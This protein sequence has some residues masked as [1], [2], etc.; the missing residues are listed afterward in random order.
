M[1][2]RHQKIFKPSFE[3]LF[4]KFISIPIEDEDDL[5]YYFA[6]LVNY[7]RPQKNAAIQ[8]VQLKELL[9]TLKNPEK[10]AAFSD[11][12]IALF[13]GRQF[14]TILTDAG[15]LYNTYFRREL[16]KRIIANFIPYQPEK[17]KLEYF[18]NQVFYQRRDYEWISKID[19]GDIDELIELL[20]ISHIYGKLIPTSPLSEVVQAI[21]LNLQR[22]TGSALESAVIKMVPEY[23]E[24]ESPFEALEKE[25]DI[26]EQKIH[27]NAY[28]TFNPEDIDLR[29]F[30]VLSAQC[31]QFIDAA[32]N[33]SSKYGI[34]L[35]VNQSL[36]RIR[37]QL[38]RTEILIEFFVVQDKKEAFQKTTRL[39][40]LLI[41]YNCQKNNIRTLIAEST[42]LISYEVTQHTAK[43]GEHYITKGRREYFSMLKSSTFGGFIVGFLCIFKLYIHHWELSQFGY[44]FFYSMN[45]AFGFIT[46]YLI[47]AT[48]A[49]KQPAMTASAMIQ[50]IE[51]DRHETDRFKRYS[52]FSELTSRLIRS[53]FI[54][55]VG[56]IIGTFSMALLLIYLIQ[57]LTGTNAAEHDWPKLIKDCSPVHSLAIFH[58]AIAGVFL[59]LSG[60]ISGSV[61]NSNKHNRL[62]YRIKEH[63]V[64][65]RNLGK[66]KAEKIASWLEKKWPGVASNFWFGV[67]MGT[68]ASVGAFLGLNLDVRHITFSTGNFAIGNFGSDFG[69]TPDMIFW[70][71][72]GIIIIG[73]MNFI[74]SFI[75]SLG[76]ALRS[77][78]IAYRELIPLFKAVVLRFRV[79]PLSF[80]LPPR[81]G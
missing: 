48:L 22:M 16:K 56:N 8:S 35:D 46:I 21:R 66:A 25:F 13:S 41:K 51:K 6:D 15:I 67:F 36:L 47:G 57:L 43:T 37:Q 53:Q 14:K 9:D 74:V 20:E 52:A 11:R 26:L 38:E 42:Q 45:Y 64:L 3:S 19:R 80:F 7:Y 12:L 33:N 44:A 17:T 18:L 62:Y 49:T 72:T 63:P 54:A 29:H 24:R 58:A 34:S 65:K 32:Y 76:L 55:F 77:R 75:L 79:E 81:K 2:L 30:K 39:L 78:D 50:S 61:A 4:Q 59:F 60:I 73:F 28:H 68:T 23:E 40:F 31:H 5:V 10:K 1:K 69:L 71:S 70:A 27:T